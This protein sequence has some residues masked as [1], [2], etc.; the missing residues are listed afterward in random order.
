M[1]A[2]AD[3][4]LSGPRG[5]RL[6]LEYA[7]A[8]DPA[9][10]TAAFL[11]AHAG[12]GRGESV[13]LYASEDGTDARDLPVPTLESLA[14]MV[15]ALPPTP[16]E[17]DAVRA[18]LRRSVDTAY[19]WQ[20]PDAEDVLAALP[21]IRSALIPVAEHVLLSPAAATW[22]SPATTTQWAVDWRPDTARPLPTGAAALLD[23]WSAARRADEEQSARERPSDPRASVSGSW[24][25]LPLRL[26][27]TRSR[28]E[29]LLELV[30]DSGG[31][32]A[33]TVTP[34]TGAGRT[35][36]IGSAE[37]WAQLCRAYPAEVTASRRHD[38]HRVTGGE[39]RWLLPDWQR[40]AA[41]WDAVH[42]TTLGYLSSATRLIP[43]DD[44]Y[45]SV[46][47]GW[48]PDSTLWLTDGARESDA[49]RQQ[50]RRTDRDRWERTG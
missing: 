23:E 34:V 43:V 3:A 33:A 41:D 36:E 11:L 15:E 4:L 25:S 17:D 35:L 5:R 46:I 32:D 45:A 18:A 30:E 7:T 21:E 27:R 19:S 14:A 6:C 28:I 37:D 13:L 47:A 26:L 40:A 16:A 24:W 12:G 38:W 9:L 44:E 42:L 49:P 1:S 39:G 50:W 22:T 20:E 48:A 29:D 10:H 2:A 31:L 8:A